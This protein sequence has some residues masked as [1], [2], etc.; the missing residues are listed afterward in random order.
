MTVLPL[1]SALIIDRLY[2]RLTKFK[3]HI[4]ITLNFQFSDPSFDN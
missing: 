4:F 2:S 3:E 1:C